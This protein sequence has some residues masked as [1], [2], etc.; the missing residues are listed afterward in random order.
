MLDLHQLDVYQEVAPG[1]IA[2]PLQSGDDLVWVRRAI[3]SAP[4]D[5]EPVQIHHSWLTGLGDDAATALAAHD[6]ALPWPGS[7]AASHRPHHHT[8]QQHTQARAASPFEASTFGIRDGAA[9]L[10]SHLTT[11]DGA[12][13]PI[14]HSRFAW[15]ADAVQIS[16]QYSY[17]ASLPQQS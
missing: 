15:P 2:A 4:A 17:P 10:V 6:P 7:S 1:H 16:T 14:E 8:V 3:H 9:V 5:P 12:H 13:R 11:Y